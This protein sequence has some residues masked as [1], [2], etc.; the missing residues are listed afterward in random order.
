MPLKIEYMRTADLIPYD[1][2]AKEH[3]EKQVEQI[4]E[5]IKDFGFLDPV[6]IDENN[7][8]IEGHG[9]LLAA[10]LLSMDKIPVIR[11]KGLT[12]AQ[13]RAY[14]L[15]HNQLTMNTG[16][17]IAQLEIE[18][19]NITGIDIGKYDID[20]G[21]KFNHEGIVPVQGYDAENDEREYFESGFTF[22]TKYKK[23]IISYLKKH[24][25]EI[26]ENIIL[27]ACE[28]G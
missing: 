28:N 7:V 22:P 27:E 9:R 13:K 16:F 26:T 1:G 19:D 8:L 20:I 4:A 12:E 14:T 17:D 5:S 3:P 2:N 11:L 15:V 6:A 24:K 23:Q 10:Q 18:L 21:E 25:S